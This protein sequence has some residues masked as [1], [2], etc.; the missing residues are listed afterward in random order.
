MKK[1][2]DYWIEQF[3]LIR[4][5][6]GGYFREIYRSA[7]TIPEANLPDRFDGSRA[8]STS[9]YFLLKENDFSAFHQLKADEIWHFYAGSTLT[10]FAINAQGILSQIILGEDF[11]NG[12]VFQA[13]VPAGHWF[14][15]KVN[16][17]DSYALV[18]CTMAPG[19][20]YQDFKLGKRKELIKEFPQH[21]ALIDELTRS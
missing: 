10:I 16:N 5:E 4:H 21:K 12:E 14:A 3:K 15:A 11:D 18:G 6:E 20:E 7:E 13:V 1:N 8:F 2:A 17:P 19:F 9:I